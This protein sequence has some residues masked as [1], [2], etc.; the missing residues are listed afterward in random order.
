MY[1]LHVIRKNFTKNIFVEN[2]LANKNHSQ[3]IFNLNI[4]CWLMKDYNKI[5]TVSNGARPHF[6]V[7]YAKKHSIIMKRIPK[8]ISKVPE[9]TL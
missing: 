5:A 2:I 1:A 4:A 7:D 8:S 3:I 9:T 6:R